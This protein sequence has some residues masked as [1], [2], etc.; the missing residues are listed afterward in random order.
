MAAQRTVDDVEFGSKFRAAGIGRGRCYGMA[1]RFHVV[2]I[3]L[4]RFAALRSQ[5]V[6]GL[7][8]A[9]FKRL[10]ARDV[11]RLFEFAGVDAEV[12]VA[13]LEHLAQLGEAQGLVDRQGADDG[14]AQALVDQAVEPERLLPRRPSGAQAP[15]LGFAPLGWPS[16]ARTVPQNL[17]HR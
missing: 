4:E 14:Q 7:R 9:A 8:H 3:L 17:R 15:L 11:V 6:L 12:A 5:P 13:G 16:R 10:G 2:E 1:Q